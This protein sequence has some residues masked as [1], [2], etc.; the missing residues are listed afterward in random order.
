[1]LWFLGID[2]A[3]ASLEVALMDGAGGWQTG[4]FKNTPAGFTLC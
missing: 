1:M 3:K 2:V 4:N